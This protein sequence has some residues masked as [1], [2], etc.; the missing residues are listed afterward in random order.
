LA[1][2]LGLRRG[3][4]AKVTNCETGQSLV[5]PVVPTDRVKGK[6]VWVNFHKSKAEIEHGRYLNT[7]TSHTGRCPYSSQTNMKLT[8]VAIERVE[9]VRVS[10][11]QAPQGRVLFA[12]VMDDA[13][14]TTAVLAA[15]A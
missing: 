6:A 2:Q 9:E 11:P 7:L 5:L 14:F 12:H 13:A 8:Q 10:K 4:R 3:D 1:E 15:V